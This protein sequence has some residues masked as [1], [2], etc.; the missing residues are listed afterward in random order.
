MLHIALALAVGFS[1]P[2]NLLPEEA[3]PAPAS[4]PSSDGKVYLSCDI[5]A[6]NGDTGT[7]RLTIDLP[8]SS[9]VE[10]EAIFVT[11]YPVSLGTDKIEFGTFKM[12]Y[13]TVDR[14]TLAY[15]QENRA[16]NTWR[17]GQCTL[18]APPANRAF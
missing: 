11:S 15:K 16:F 1:A 10:E 13:T 3:P 12:G 17:T 8:Q 2:A 7:V 18:A 5:V 9:V 14:R 6:Q 4:G